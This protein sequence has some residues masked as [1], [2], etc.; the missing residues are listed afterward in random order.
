MYCDLL[1]SQM[2]QQQWI[3]L[4]Y[5]FTSLNRDPWKQLKH[6][7]VIIWESDGKAECSARLINC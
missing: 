6:C 2:P 1:A 7:E 5:S 4:A 3:L